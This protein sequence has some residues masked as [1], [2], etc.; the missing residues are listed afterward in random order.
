[1][2]TYITFYYGNK[3][4]ALSYV[5]NILKHTSAEVDVDFLFINSEIDTK[6][7]G[8]YLLYASDSIFQDM[9]T[10]NSEMGEDR[11]KIAIK[12]IWNQ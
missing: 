7:T 10:I 2:S 4:P 5:F 8:K 3:I 11:M 12:T 1:M 9:K 6:K